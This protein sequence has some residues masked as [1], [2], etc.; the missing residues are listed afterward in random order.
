M[1]VAQQFLIR[2]ILVDSKGMSSSEIRKLIRTTAGD[3]LAFVSKDRELIHKFRV[4]QSENGKQVM[5]E[6][7]LKEVLAASARYFHSGGV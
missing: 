4:Y 3:L 2:R 5:P 1:K 7:E 6:R